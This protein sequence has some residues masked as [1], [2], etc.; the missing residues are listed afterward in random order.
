MYKLRRPVFLMVLN[1]SERCFK[2]SK[3][4]LIRILSSIFSSSD[5][6]DVEYSTHTKHTKHTKPKRV[7]FYYK[8]TI[9][10]PSKKYQLTPRLINKCWWSNFHYD[11]FLNN[12]LIQ[13]IADL[14]IK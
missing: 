2:A 6:D 5:I 11:E 3:K 7:R 10:H 14:K 1:R 12:A 8:V 13:K 4:T 9:L